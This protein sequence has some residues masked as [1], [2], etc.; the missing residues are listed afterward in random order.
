LP[1]GPRPP[2]AAQGARSVDPRH[3]ADARHHR[4]SDFD[5]TAK[6]NNFSTG[7]DLNGVPPMTG[8]GRWR[9]DIDATRIRAVRSMI[10]PGYTSVF[11]GPTR[12]QRQPSRPA[13]RRHRI[14]GTQAGQVN[15]PTL[16][17]SNHQIV[18]TLQRH[19]KLREY[20]GVM[21]L[22]EIPH[23]CSAKFLTLGRGQGSGSWPVRVAR[24][25]VSAR[26]W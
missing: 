15:G 7:C 4:S 2:V 12:R 11:H 16:Q 9:L 20:V 25:L 19:P 23:L 10:G 3:H 6:I 17:T 8:R 1:G 13:G 22:I 24:R 14:S 21:A 18:H 5:V 26:A